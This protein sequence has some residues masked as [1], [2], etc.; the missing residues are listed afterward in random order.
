[1][2][3]KIFR[4]TGINR[5]NQTTVEYVQAKTTEDAHRIAAAYFMRCGYRLFRLREI[6]WREYQQILEKAL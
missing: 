5:A 6:E 1:M 2:K 3:N 4:A